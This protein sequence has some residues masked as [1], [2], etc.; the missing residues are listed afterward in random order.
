M[1]LIPCITPCVVLHAYL[2]RSQILL[3]FNGHQVMHSVF[4]IVSCLEVAC[5]GL[6][7]IQKHS[8]EQALVFNT[9]TIVLDI[10]FISECTI[11]IFILISLISQLS[12]YCTDLELSP[13]CMVS[14][15]K[16]F[17][18]ASMKWVL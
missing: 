4:C 1:R 12:C 7:L 15:E 11:I 2:R 3:T 9:P 16:Q 10:C 14:L 13:L 8:E 5:K 6:F 17:L 18:W